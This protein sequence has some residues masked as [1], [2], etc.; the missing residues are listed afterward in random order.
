VLDAV[1]DAAD[2]IASLHSIERQ[3]DQQVKAQA[4]TESAYELAT[5]RYKAGI[6][7]YLTVLNAEASVLVQRRLAADLKARLLD[8]QIALIR[9]LGGGYVPDAE[10]ASRT[11][12]AAH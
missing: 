12:A 2:Q 11:A 3:Q 5:Q 7:G 8:T 1:H 9:S 4:A 6:G 10:L